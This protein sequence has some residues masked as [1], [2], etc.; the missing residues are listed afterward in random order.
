MKPTELGRTIIGIKGAG[1]MATGVAV[2]L[3]R[4]GFSRI[5]MME[6]EA[7]LAVRR[8]VSFCEAIHDGRAV[9]EAIEAVRVEGK[10]GITA[11]W[12]R[13]QLAVLVDPEWTV[14]EEMQTG[15]LIDA[16]IAKRNLG[17]KIEDAPL[18][19]GLGPGFTASVDVHRVV[20]TMR[21]H[22]MGRVIETGSA[23]ANTGVPGNIGGYTVER[24]LRSPADGT[25]QTEHEIT[26]LVK[27][28]EVVCCVAGKE[29]TAKI[30]GV[31]RGLIREGTAVS[32]GTKIG[33]IDPRANVTFCSTV[34]EKSRAIGGAVLEAI[35]GAFT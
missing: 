29:V 2:R 33:D 6:I 35:L 13:G 24:V 31:V 19:I 21:G 20:E 1:E 4:A 34:S 14:L 5:F 28:G 8:G 12:G 3:N 7:P 30:S 26:D 18:V 16:T 11:A 9:V 15:V 27:A 17:T 25:F 22:D 32:K 23:Q 10:S